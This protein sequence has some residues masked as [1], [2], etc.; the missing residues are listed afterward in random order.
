MHYYSEKKDENFVSNKLMRMRRANC[1]KVS[2]VLF[3][4]WKF[5]RSQLACYQIL[6]FHCATD[7]APHCLEKQNSFY[8]S[9][10]CPIWVTV[11]QSQDWIVFIHRLSVISVW[12]GWFTIINFA[13][14]VRLCTDFL[15]CYFSCSIHG[16]GLDVAVFW[17]YYHIHV[18]WW[19][20]LSEEAI[21]CY[22]YRRF[23]P[24]NEAD[25]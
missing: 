25:G 22:S 20:I 16:E 12:E 5:D 24:T 19:T 18:H 10:N 9:T 8:Y 23:W 1:P 2:F 17:F 6:F 13:I 11:V 4:W 15:R 14:E 7:A 21:R 3:Q